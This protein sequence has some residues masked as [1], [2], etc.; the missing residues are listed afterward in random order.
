[1]SASYTWSKSLA[2][3]SGNGDGVDAGEDPFDRRL[4]FGPTSF[5]RRHI[6]VTTYTYRIPFFRKWNSVARTALS[7]WELSGITR[8]QTGPLLTVRGGTSIGTRRANYLGGEVNLP[9]SQRTIDRWFNEEAFEPAADDGR[10][11]SGRGIVL[12]PGR[13]LWDIS[14]RKRF[15]ISEAVKLQLQADF[16]NAFNQTNFGSGTNFVNLDMPALVT[17]PGAD[18]RQNIKTSSFGSISSAA[19]GRNVQ[20]G[21]KL[22]F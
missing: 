20:L 3:A 17:T 1:M 7:G 14:M 18:P 21:L 2:D 22:T 6:F 19:P 4:N 11:N 5:D 9:S 8:F 15:G 12:G 10:G 13:R 16:F